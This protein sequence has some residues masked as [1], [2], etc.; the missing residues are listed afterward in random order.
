MQIVRAVSAES[1]QIADCVRAAYQH[2]VERIGTPPG[3]MLDDYDAMISEHSVWVMREDD[4]V[5]AVL[6][7]MARP[8]CLLLDNV[9]VN[10]KHQGKGYGRR[11]I[12]FAE[13]EA[14]QC[15]YNEI[16]LYTH[17]LMHENISIYERYGYEEIDRREERGFSRVYMRKVLCAV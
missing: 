12:K 11:L 5:A 3:P 7:L 13:A 16:Q 2:Y 14:R 9:A 8:N 15:G 1:E 4:Q 10:P 17:E 6:V